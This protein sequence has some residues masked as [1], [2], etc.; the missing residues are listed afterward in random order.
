MKTFN[1]LSNLYVSL[2][3]NS[4]AENVSL[5]REMIND[6]HR[7][8]LQKYF[9][10]ENSYSTTTVSNQG[11]YVLPPNYS[12]MK[13]VTIQIGSNGLKYTPVEILTRREWDQINMLPY[14]SDIPYFY[15]IYNGIVNIFPIPSST[16]N[17]ITFNYKI[18]VPDLAVNDYTT[19]TVN[20]TNGSVTVEGVTTAWITNFLPGAGSVINESLWIKFDYPKGDGNWYQISSIDAEDSLTLVAP[21]QG[22]DASLVSYTIGQVPLVIEDFQDLLTYRPLTIYFS[23]VVPDASR[24][25]EFKAIYNDG[26][27]RLDD[28]SGSKSVN[29]DLGD[30]ANFVN[31]N[32]FFFS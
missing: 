7:Y 17:V 29:V 9:N 2:S 6:T 4:S 30:K 26:I 5:G 13:D 31:P 18:R 22:Q 24:A 19:G 27:A 28:Y 23:S 25:S 1:T 8:L 3:Q 16:G 20:L 21:Y 32:L 10:N 12:K 15:F 11:G 14:T